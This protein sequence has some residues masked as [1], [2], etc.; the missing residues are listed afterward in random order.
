MND[1]QAHNLAVFTLACVAA[2]LLAFAVTG[3][4]IPGFSAGPAR[5]LNVAGAAAA[6][7]LI[8]APNLRARRALLF[9]LVGYLAVRG[10]AAFVLG[11]AERLGVLLL[12]AVLANVWT[13]WAG[14]RLGQ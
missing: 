14:W 9:F 11:G 3:S 13:T 6:A 1:R 7:A 10:V 4:A 2:I 8:V 5:V 12:W